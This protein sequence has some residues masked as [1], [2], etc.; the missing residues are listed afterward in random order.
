MIHLMSEYLPD[1]DKK[2]RLKT[3][4]KRFLLPLILLIPLQLA[5]PSQKDLAVIFAGHWVL[6]SKEVKQLP[7]KAVK[8]LNTYM[9]N[10]LER[11][12]K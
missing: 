7:E 9:D 11:H 5:I 6:N 10:Y 2:P 8:V 12:K 3:L 1:V 4:S